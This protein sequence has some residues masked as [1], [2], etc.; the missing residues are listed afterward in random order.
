LEIERSRLTK[1]LAE[2]YEKQGDLQKS[3]ETL[4]LVQIETVSTMDVAEKI[5]FIL[6]QLRLC[7]ETKD[8]VKAMIMSKKITEKSLSLHQVRNKHK[9]RI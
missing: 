3:S 4:Q 9:I 2:I 1:E 7:L 5:S 6:E 8:F